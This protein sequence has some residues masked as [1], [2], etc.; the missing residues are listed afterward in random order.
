MPILPT[1]KCSLFCNIV[2]CFYFLIFGLVFVGIAGSITEVIFKYVYQ[3]RLNY[4]K[5]CEGKQ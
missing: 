3:I 1:G 4:G 2:C 5:E